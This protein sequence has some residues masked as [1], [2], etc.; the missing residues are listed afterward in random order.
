MS[1][2]PFDF[3]VIAFYFLFM[4]GIG[5]YFR[6]FTKNASEY[7]RGGGQMTWWLVGASAFMA[8][9]SAWTFTGAASTAYEFGLV[10]MVIYFC[11]AVG[12]ILNY[13]HFAPWFRQMR[14]ITVMQAVR[15]RFSAANEQFFTWLQ[16]P[17]QLLYAGIWLFGLAIFFSSVFK[18]NLAATIIVTG[19]AVL[20]TATIGGS[21][22]VVAGDFLQALILLPITFVVAFLALRE[23]G[24]VGALIEKI[25]ASHLDITGSAFTEYGWLWVVAM[26]INKIFVLNNMQ[27]AARYLCVKDGEAA[28]KA[29]LMSAIL[30]VVGPIIWFIPPLAARALFPDLSGMLPGIK[31]PSEGAYV[32]IAMKTMPAGL[33][34][35]LVT[36]IFSATMSSMDTGLNRNA[37]VFVKNVYQP[38]FRPRAS[39]H[40]LV[41][42][43]KL[44]S[45][46]M[47]LLVIG[48]A[49][50][51]STWKDMGLFKLMINFTALVGI[52]YSISLLWCLV[53]KKTPAWSGWSTVL[54]SLA[55][56]L[57]VSQGHS[58]EWVRSSLAWLGA[59][60]VAD[61]VKAHDFVAANFFIITV[62]TAWFF[63][64]RLF[65]DRTSA[66]YKER[67]EGFFAEMHRPV[68][69][70]REIG[71]DSDN[72]Q[73]VAL[74][75]LCFAYG[76]FVA[77][78]VVIPNPLIGRACILFCSL[79]LLVTGWLLQ[80]SARH[81][82]ADSAKNPAPVP[83][84]S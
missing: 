72:R 5:W 23:V 31:N 62:G 56:S 1:L 80:R 3:L 78:L 25:P 19:L 37:G 42:V 69:F 65:Y 79:A 47:G 12:F 67:V 4:I 70:A 18:M 61:W 81:P 54:V 40:E 35:L 33:M 59:P 32:V 53:V 21:W 82:A 36:G 9:F 46:V 27:D 71:E 63:A 43:G 68:D 22:A 41:R 49:L 29:A 66:E 24:G 2:S 44:T 7:F 83:A 39:E 77:L 55:A 52:P 64:T 75:R 15:T 11:N 13:T 10:I 73:A 45:I 51:Y 84:E 26:L 60:G 28:R 76:V 14:V 58:W 8:S 57:L 17:V 74:A 6:R 38:L 34:G 48:I 16:L 50:V 20:I 30:F